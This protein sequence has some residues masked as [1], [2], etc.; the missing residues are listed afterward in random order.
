MSSPR[1]ESFRPAFGRWLTGG[2]GLVCGGAAV[3]GLFSDGPSA[4]VTLW[5]WLLLLVGGC[6]AVFWRPE[7]RA[8]EDGV[9]LVNVTHTVEV[10]WSTLIGLETKWALT[11]VTAERVFRAWAAPAPGRSAMRSKSP[12]THRLRDAAVGGEIRPGDLPETDSG[13][14]GVL[15]RRR[16][17]AKIESGALDDDIADV[18]PVHFVWH[19]PQLGGA[20]VL[21]VVAVLGLV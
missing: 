20:L 10:P 2:F 4:I 15:I 18:A 11:L 13:A 3:A 14:A 7:V 12:N 19:W 21:V 8:E 9:V 5:P 1:G 6:W 16:W 17:K